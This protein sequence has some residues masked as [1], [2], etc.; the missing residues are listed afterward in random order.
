M[1]YSKLPFIVV[2]CNSNAITNNNFL[3]SLS[4]FSFFLLSLSLSLSLSLFYFLSSS[5]PLPFLP[6]LPSLLFFQLKNSNSFSFFAFLN[7]LFSL[8]LSL[9]LV[10]LLSQKNKEVG[11]RWFMGDI[12]GGDNGNGLAM[13][14]VCVS[15]I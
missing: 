12:S 7:S 2:F 4:P 15:C 11:L 10:G 13:W 6:S 9:F 3:L 14:W 5:V 8:S 1:C